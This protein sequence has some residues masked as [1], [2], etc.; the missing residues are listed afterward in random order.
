MIKG[1]G[2][3]PK[4][5]N[6][7]FK[8]F[9]LDK[10]NYADNLFEYNPER[11]DEE[12][13]KAF[14]KYLADS[15]GLF[16]YDKINELDFVYENVIKEGLDLNAKITE[17]TIGKNKVYKAEDGER[18]ILISLDK[19]IHKANVEALKGKEYKEKI[20]VCFDTALDDSAKAN[21]ALNVS[22]KTI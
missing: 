2:D 13:E 7:G 22:L 1:Y 4:P 17:M 11:T 6:D 12:N 21:L 8:V 9:K 15:Q 16:H 19:Q 14:R 20:F 10:S 3:N 18:E 5:I